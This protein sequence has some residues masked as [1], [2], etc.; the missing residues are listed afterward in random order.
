MAA[1][2]ALALHGDASTYQRYLPEQTPLYALIEEHFPRF[3]ERLEAEGALLPY[4]ANE[5]FEAYLKC[6]RLEYG[7]P[8]RQVR[9]LPA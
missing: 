8:A 1:S 4:F 5:E 7:I 9:R 3:L 6:G 2:T